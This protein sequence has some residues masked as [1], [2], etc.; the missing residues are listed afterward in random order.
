MAK[1]S[2][3]DVAKLRKMTGAGMMDCKRALG[4]ANGDFEEAID[5]LRKKGQKVAGKRAER[6]ASEGAVLAKTNSD[7]TKAIIVALNCETDFVAKNKDFIKFTQKI[8]D[9]AVEKNPSNLDEL[10]ELEINGTKISEEITNQIGIIGEKLELS[11]FDKIEAEYTTVYIH[12]GN[13]LVS[14]AGFNKNIFDNQVAKD[15]VMQI[16]AMAPVAIDKNDVPQSVID[17]EIEIGREQAIQEGKP[18]KLAEM[19]SKG[20]LNKF[21]KDNTLLNQ[22]FIKNNKQTVK[23]YLKTIDK[24]L[25]VTSF[26]RYL[27][28]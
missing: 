1:I 7:S 2:A 22:Q 19:I 10:K 14:I 23:D 20:K 4:E 5:V 8:L 16:A 26:K 11:Y 24:N 12:P 6:D 18:E 3:K 25:S 27:L 15:V 9:I 13:K 17:K 21:F 28:G